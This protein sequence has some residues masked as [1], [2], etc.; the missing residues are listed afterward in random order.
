MTTQEVYDKYVHLDACLSDREWM[1]ESIVAQVF[2]DLW[3]AIKEEQNGEKQKID[4]GDR[5]GE[6]TRTP[7][8]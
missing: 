2:Y 4:G 6:C 1:G 3:Q 7:G 5:E 8:D